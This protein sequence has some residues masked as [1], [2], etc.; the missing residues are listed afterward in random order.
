MSKIVI[1]G[2]AGFI[3]SHIADSLAKDGHE[4]IIVD[5]LDPYYSIDLKKRNV[6]MVLKNENVT[7]INSDITN[8]DSL[9]EIIDNTIDYVYHE[10]AQPGVRMSIKDPFKPNNIN[11]VGTLNVLMTSLDSDIKRIINASSS[12]VYGTVK[13]LPFDENHPTMPIS[14]YG[15]SKLAAEHYC[16]I[17]YEIY[18]LPTVSLRYFTVYGPRMRPDLAIYKFT[19][20]ILNDIPITIFGDGNQTRDFTYIDDII[21]VNIKLLN[22]NKADGKVMNLGSGN[23][24]SVNELVKLLEEIIGKKVKII[25]DEEYKGDVIHTLANI[26]LAKKLICYMPDTPIREG[27]HKFINSEQ[28]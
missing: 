27:L 3:G 9:K 22:T 26:E 17:F 23:R 15:A 28:F 19:K 14:P 2:G 10:A 11:I 20:N 4:I 8:L 6:G 16:R 24:I 18:G 12:S 5:N 1:T 7:F 13:Y 21:G 25:Y